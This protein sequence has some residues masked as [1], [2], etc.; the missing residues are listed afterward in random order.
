[1]VFLVGIA[2]LMGLLAMYL[3]MSKKPGAVSKAV[4]DGTSPPVSGKKIKEK[5]QKKDKKE[6]K[7]TLKEDIEEEPQ[8]DTAVSRFSDSLLIFLAIAFKSRPG[9][10]LP[11]LDR[12]SAVP[13]TIAAIKGSEH[14]IIILRKTMVGRRGRCLSH[15]S[16]AEAS[17]SRGST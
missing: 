15:T 12:M 9:G 17:H 1:M 2:F 13:S 11:I 7:A 4:V 3:I 5:K 16:C 8:E 10:S 6:A 14:S